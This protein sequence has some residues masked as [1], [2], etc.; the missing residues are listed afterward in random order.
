[1]NPCGHDDKD[2]PIEITREKFDELMQE[3]QEQ[4]E[5]LA[6]KFARDVQAAIDSFKK[7]EAWAKEQVAAGVT[8][9]NHLVAQKISHVIDEAT[10]VLYFTTLYNSFLEE[11]TEGNE[12]MADMLDLIAVLDLIATF[13]DH[14]KKAKSAVN[15]MRLKKKSRWFV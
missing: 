11:V 5:N 8:P 15:E 7:F 12:K 3:N 6:N 13:S 9:C 4:F 14:K 10:K 1:M 2:F